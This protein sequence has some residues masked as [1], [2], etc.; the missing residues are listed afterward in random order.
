MLTDKELSA[1][2]Q[3]WGNELAQRNIIDL[4]RDVARAQE[5]AERERCAKL[6]QVWEDT[7]TQRDE[8]L[9]HLTR[10]EPLPAWAVEW[11]RVHRA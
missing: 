8:L 9:A 1:I 7:R 3:A 10:K 6:Q 2:V 4:C 5:A 11:I